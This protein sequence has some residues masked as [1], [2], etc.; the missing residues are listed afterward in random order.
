MSD[1]VQTQFGWH[2]IKLE[3][4]RTTEAPSFEEL[5]GQL[6]QQLTRA[7]AQAIIAEIKGEAD[8]EKMEETPPAFLIRREEMYS[9]VE[10]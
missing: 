10:K 1:P 6:R 2:V 7:T 9:D 5:E 3:D 8:V 4:R